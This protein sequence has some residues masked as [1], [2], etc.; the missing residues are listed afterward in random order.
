MVE[1]VDD[2]CDVVGVVGVV[3]SSMGLL[4]VLSVIPE[5]QVPKNPKFHKYPL[6]YSMLL[7]L[8]VKQNWS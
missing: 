5:N 7:A 1:V 2:G 6:P 4:E 8:S 3:E